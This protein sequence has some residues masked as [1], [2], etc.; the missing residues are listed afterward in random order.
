MLS[1]N[2][3]TKYTLPREGHPP[4]VSEYSEKKPRVMLNVIVL[5]PPYFTV[6]VELELSRSLGMNIYVSHCTYLIKT[7]Y[8]STG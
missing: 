5:P 8:I 7:A 1:H 3:N 6:W 2:L 4:K